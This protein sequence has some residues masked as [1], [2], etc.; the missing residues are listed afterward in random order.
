MDQI[1][2]LENRQ[3]LV[4]YSDGN[5]ILGIRLPLRRGS[6]LLLR[7]GYL[8]DLSA[9]SYEGKARFVWHSLEHHIVLSSAEEQRDQV[10]LSDIMNVRQYGGLRLIAKDGGLY[11]LYSGYEPVGQKW[12]GYVMKLDGGQQEPMKLKGDYER[13]PALKARRLAGQWLLE[14]GLA[15]QTEIYFWEEDPEPMPCKER[16]LEPLRKELAEKDRQIQSVSRQY[17][18]LREVAIRLQEDGRKMRDYIKG[19]NRHFS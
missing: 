2:E 3:R 1:L 16:I 6:D 19:Q 5:A 17:G 8:S 9:V 15:G 14:F 13:R 12:N 7:E 4:I 11:L 18:E 10:I